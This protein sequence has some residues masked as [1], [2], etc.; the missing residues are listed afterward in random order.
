MRATPARR[1]PRMVVQQRP[2][3]PPMITA[4]WDIDGTLVESPGNRTDLFTEATAAFGVDPI[5]PDGP[6]D[7]FTDRR[8]A[9]VHLHAA[10]LAPHLV[11]DFLDRLDVMS[12]DFYGHTPRVPVPGA[13]AAVTAT[14]QQ[15]WRN[16][17]LTG[18]TPRRARVK[19]RTSGFDLDAFDW[20]CFA[21]GAFV[22]D[23]EQLG[24]Q[25]RALAGPGPLVVLGDT[26]QDVL[27][28]NAAGAAFVA[29]NTDPDLLL[30][31]A[32]DAVLAVGSLA[33]AEFL[34]FVATYTG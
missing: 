1:L 32:D 14:K 25:A 31:I 15:G 4:F 27:A 24:R 18:N 8:L 29:V 6:R 12:E 17:L 9:E 7:G 16:G 34:D 28:A 33:S 21:S 19:L 30:A 26:V 23:R 3:L 11:D 22:S 2:R 5:A 20:S 10:G 13:R